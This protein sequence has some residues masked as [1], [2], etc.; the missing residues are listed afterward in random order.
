MALTDFSSLKKNRSK[1]LDKLNSQLDKISSN[2]YQ[3]PN[4]GKFWKPTRD[5]AGNGFAVIRF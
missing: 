2:S 1:T 5:K 4:A 3:D